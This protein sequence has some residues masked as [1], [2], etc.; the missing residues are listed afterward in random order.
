MPMKALSGVL[1]AMALLSG[2]AQA[3]EVPAD[4][5]A[6]CEGLAHAFPELPADAVT[7]EKAAVL[8]E[9]GC[10]YS[11]VQIR[12]NQ[13]LSWMV[14]T[15]AIDRIDFT[16]AYAGLPPLTLSARLDGIAYNQ[17]PQSGNAAIRYYNRLTQKPFGIAL[18]YAFD[19]A[20]RVLTLK[21]FT[22]QGERLGR[23]S[24][25][26]EIGDVDP[27]LLDPLHTPW[28]AT[29]PA[30]SLRDATAYLDNQG[31]IE[32]FAL[33]SILNALPGG[34]EHPEQAVA[35]AKTAAVAWIQATLADSLPGASVTALTGFIQDLPQP[36]RPVTMAAHPATPVSVPALLLG[37]RRPGQTEAELI[38]DLGLTVT[39]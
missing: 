23:L 16:R 4:P 20:S 38:R 2:P 33:M 9:T 5:A 3:A 31:L 14:D 18:D 37:E 12:V 1:L 21:D 25:T 10:R 8:G 29:V 28:P 24:L 17:P 13:Y 36:K 27:A 30:V 22:M 11:G 7:F 26:A 34:T 15:L 39:Y 35:Q 6:R 19:P 32:R